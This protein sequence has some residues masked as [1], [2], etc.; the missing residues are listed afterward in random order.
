MNINIQQLEGL[1]ISKYIIFDI[2]DN[3]AYM[4]GYIPGALNV[5]PEDVEEELKAMA[6]Q[7]KMTSDK[8][9]EMIGEENI[10][11]LEKDLK[12]KKAIDLIYDNA[13]KK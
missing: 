5:K 4:H 13:V 2:R 1:E 3:I 10:K 8:I 9:R 12:V 11:L 6:E 7:Y